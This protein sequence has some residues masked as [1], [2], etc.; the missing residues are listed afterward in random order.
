MEDVKGRTA[1]ITGGARGIGLG[2][3]RAFA[4]A[5]IKVALAD[6]DPDSLAAAKSDLAKLTAVETF[7]LDVRDR[8][9]Y[10]RVADEAEAR[11]GPVIN[12]VQQR[13]RRRSDPFY[14]RILGLDARNQPERRS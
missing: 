12:P 5:G 2:I 11:L 7:K 6:I 8:E 3:A 14:I 13:R 10:A 1:F 9:G 4:H